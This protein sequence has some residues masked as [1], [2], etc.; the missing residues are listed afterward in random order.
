MPEADQN[1]LAAK[2]SA[3]HCYTSFVDVVAPVGRA[4][5]FGAGG[6]IRNTT[7]SIGDLFLTSGGIVFIPYHPW[8]SE[9]NWLIGAGTAA[10]GVATGGALW[11][12]GIADQSEAFGAAK[13]AR[14]SD[15]GKPIERRIRERSGKV[16]PV[17]SVTKTE[18]DSASGLV[19][20]TTQTGSIVL[21]VRDAVTVQSCLNNLLA[22]TIRDEPDFQGVNGT[23][24][25]PQDLLKLLS[26]SNGTAVSVDVRTALNALPSNEEQLEAFMEQFFLHRWAGVPGP[27]PHMKVLETAA[28]NSPTLAMAIPSHITIKLDAISRKKKKGWLWVAA[29]ALVALICEVFIITNGQGQMW[30]N[31]GE[32]MSYVGAIQFFS[33]LGLL[34][35]IPIVLL[36][37]SSLNGEAKK[38][39]TMLETLRKLTPLPPEHPL[40]CR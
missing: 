15:Y 5:Y 27:A 10:G 30:D 24:I 39:R 16:I 23:G 36:S 9:P 33:C 35:G 28:L 19:R 11:L 25:P 2:P 22:G 1:V 4:S 20:I 18:S 21:A 29:F 3:E 12:Y 13:C 26:E 31:P 7:A 17:D 8:P 40:I 34:F 32:P 6:L 38:Y 37:H 14:E